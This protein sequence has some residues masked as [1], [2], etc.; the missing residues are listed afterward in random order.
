[1]HPKSIYSKNTFISSTRPTQRVCTFA[2]LPQFDELSS[3][4]EQLGEAPTGGGF[5]AQGCSYYGLTGG[6]VG[7]RVSPNGYQMALVVKD[8]LPIRDILR[9]LA[10]LL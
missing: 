9:F 5:T 6:P 1:M 2:Q 7:L 10:F 3:V 8:V 4:L